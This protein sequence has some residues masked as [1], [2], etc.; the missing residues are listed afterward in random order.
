E[1]WLRCI[2]QT[3]IEKSVSLLAAEFLIDLHEGTVRKYL[4]SDLSSRLI[5]HEWM[6]ADGSRQRQFEEEIV[7]T[8]NRLMR[9]LCSSQVCRFMGLSNFNI[10]LREAMDEGKIILVNLAESEHLSHYNARLF[11][12]LLINELCQ[13]ARRRKGDEYGNPPRPFY[14]YIDEFQNFIGLDIASGLDQLRKF[15]LHFILAHQ[16]LGQIGGRD[17][18]LMD[19]ILHNTKIRAVFGGLRREDAIL[20]V[21]EMF[22]HQLDLKQIKKAIYQTKFWPKYGRDKVYSSGS[23]QSTGRSSLRSTSAVSAS[24]YAPPPEGWFE[25]PLQEPELLSTTES[26]STSFG[27]GDFES[28]SWSFAEADIP[29]FIPVPFEELSSLEYWSLDEVKWQMS[30]ALKGQFPRH[31][32]IQIPGQ[33]TQ[34]M[35][36]PYV[37]G[38]YV[39]E[40]DVKDYE[41]SL[42]EKIGA[43]PRAEADRLIAEERKI[44]EQRAE[45]F[46]SLDEI[47]ELGSRSMRNRK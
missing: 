10:S 30:E 8:K 3:L 22:V 4:T 23:S 35:L 21:E 40:E 15:G 36:V 16:R 18:D 29:I 43:L 24:H 45:D 27:E 19:A 1:R 46:V 20:M 12:A 13:Q 5:V 17:S 47:P 38:F 25:I 31:C 33:K 42:Y 6:R 28:S 32:F 2:Y 14:L 41:Q 9:F 26:E 7:S 44:L 37:K 39:S 34:P 11:G